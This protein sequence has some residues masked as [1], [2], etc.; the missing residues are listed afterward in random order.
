[1]KA[2][3]YNN[4]PRCPFCGGKITMTHGTLQLPIYLFKCQ[5]GSRCGAVVS[6]CNAETEASPITALK[7]FKK[8][9]AGL[10]GGDT[11]DEALDRN[12]CE[13]N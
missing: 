4:L 5:N 1:M 10:T 8:R 2:Q 12:G 11:A 9:T 6:F 3:I 13:E 7:F